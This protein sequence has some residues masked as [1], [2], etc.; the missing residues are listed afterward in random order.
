M[1]FDTPIY[2]QRVTQGEYNAETGN[3]GDDTI[4]EEK[5]YA[6]VTGSNTETLN[7]VYGALKQG[8]LTVRLQMPF[9]HP[10]DLI[11]VGDGK[12]AKH[13]RVDY[14]KTLRNKQIFVISEVT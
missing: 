5:R 11:R 2:F 10:F 9:E 3:H 8:S 1:R 12:S 4:T 7:L 6:S 14:S 13:Y